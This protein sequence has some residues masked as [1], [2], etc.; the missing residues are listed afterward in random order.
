[1]S[2]IKEDIV[3]GTKLLCHME[4][5]N[6]LYHKGGVYEILLVDGDNVRLSSDEGTC[7]WDMDCLMLLGEFSDW[8]ISFSV[9]I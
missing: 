2:L 4:E 5:D 8:K 6:S 3:A 7:L 1:M 9:V